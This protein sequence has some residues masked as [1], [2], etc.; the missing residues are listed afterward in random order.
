MSNS[1][2]M[3]SKVSTRDPWHRHPKQ[4]VTSRFFPLPLGQWW[5]DPSHRLS[6]VCSGS[7]IEGL[8]QL[9]M[10]RLCKER[11]EEAAL[12]VPPLL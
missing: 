9:R 7:E 11:G 1:L 2:M 10:K 5:S 3:F 4:E 8:S 6:L 12:G